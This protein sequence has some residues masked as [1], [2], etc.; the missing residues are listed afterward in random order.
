MR[1]KRGNIYAYIL[2]AFVFLLGEC[3]SAFADTSNSS[4]NSSITN[5][6]NPNGTTTTI[7]KEE[8]I[9]KYIFDPITI[10]IPGV[11]KNYNQDGALKKERGR[12]K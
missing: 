5:I 3:L 4:S 7:T 10:K 9:F 6:T 12:C 11:T 2:M 1:K 8:S